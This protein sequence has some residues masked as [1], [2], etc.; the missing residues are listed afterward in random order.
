MTVEHFAGRFAGRVAMVTGAARGMGEAEISRFAAEGAR[1]VI[2][3][4]LDEEGGRLAKELRD[5]A[6]FIHLDVSQ[7]TEWA[8][9]MEE[10]E[11]TFGRLDAL[12]N[13]AG[14][15]QLMPLQYVDAATFMRQMEV[16]ALG[17]FLGVRSS[18]ELMKRSGGGA[19]VNVSS[20]AG[21]SGLEY[22]VAYS[23][24]K[25]AV[26]GVTA[27]AAKEL[28]P[29][30]IRVNTVLPGGIDTPLLR[31]PLGDDFDFDALLSGTPV[32]RVGRVEEVTA[33]VC[34]LCSPEASYITGSELIIDGGMQACLALPAPR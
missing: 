3:D 28:G 20:I 9:A 4:I 13:N 11:R 8:A 26:R 34:F 31:G 32:G 14:I 25:H 33:A 24:S 15:A 23:A 2:A 22:Q 10:V 17:P 27:V 21:I 6:L 30:G 18:I 29:L 12:V 7:E 19:I 1:V 5:D 16:N